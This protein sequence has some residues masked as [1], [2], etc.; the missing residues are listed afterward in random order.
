MNRASLQSPSSLLRRQSKTVLFAGFGGLL[1]VMLFT[2]VDSL[3]LAQR[4]QERSA[5][6]QHDFLERSQVLNQI[7][8][9]FYLSGTYARDYILDPEPSAA[10]RNRAEVR[11]LK[12]EIGLLTRGSSTGSRQQPDH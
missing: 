7:R 1:A 4:M 11:R 5:T 12:D 9:D 8:S 10:D 3:R 2:G 6:I